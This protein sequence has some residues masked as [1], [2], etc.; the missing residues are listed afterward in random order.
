M[1]ARTST[2]RYVIYRVS[3]ILMWCSKLWLTSTAQAMKTP[4]PPPLTDLPSQSTASPPTEDSPTTAAKKAKRK[5]APPSLLRDNRIDKKPPDR[6]ARISDTDPKRM[7]KV[8]SAKQKEKY[9]L[10]AVVRDYYAPC[11]ILFD[12]APGRQSLAFELSKYEQYSV[13]KEPFVQLCAE[14]SQSDAM[15]LVRSLFVLDNSHTSQT[16]KVSSLVSISL[17]IVVDCIAVSA[18]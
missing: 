17:F 5:S 18:K 15:G 2:F 13:S 14:K 3:C 1:C 10:E 16:H 9:V 6:Q 12:C 8:V 4:L 11:C 7:E